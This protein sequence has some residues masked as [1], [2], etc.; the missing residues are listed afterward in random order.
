EVEQFRHARGRNQNVAGLKVA[1]HDQP[2]MGILHRRT[3][4]LEK[5]YSS[6]RSESTFVAIFVDGLAFDEL[7]HKVGMASFRRA[8]VEQAGN[9][10]MFKAGQNLALFSEA[11]VHELLVQ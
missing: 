11:G 4:A 10:L 9:I 8:T 2:L 1:M 5:F 6:I 3:N 7:H